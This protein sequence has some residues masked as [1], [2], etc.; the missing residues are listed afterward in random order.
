MCARVRCISFRA[1]NASPKST[2]S[3]CSTI[4]LSIPRR[5][6]TFCRSSRLVRSDQILTHL[7]L[8][9]TAFAFLFH[10]KQGDFSYRYVGTVPIQDVTAVRDLPDTE[11]TIF[12]QFNVLIIGT[13]AHRALPAALRNAFEI[14]WPGQT[15]ILCAPSPERKYEWKQD[16]AAVVQSLAADR[17][18][19]FNLFF[20]MRL[21]TE[22]RLLFVLSVFG[23]ALGELMSTRER[24]RDVP[25]IMEKTIGWLVDNDATQ[26]EGLFRISGMMTEIQHYR[27]LCDQVRRKPPP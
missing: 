15:M 6:P 23:I 21:A 26:V 3:S 13:S 5:S 20:L 2:I 11:S 8:Y 17:R 7:S 25:M 9:R 27:H 19:Y 1:T 18:T 16:I 22:N 24:D 14:A 4:F 12:S 10:H